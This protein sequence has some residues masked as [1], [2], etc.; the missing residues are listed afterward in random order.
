MNKIGILTFHYSIN[1]GAMMQVYSLSSKLKKEYPNLNV[2]VI[3]YRMPK[4]IDSYNYKLLDYLKDDNFIIT[5]KKSIKL[6]LDPLKLKRLNERTRI[7]SEAIKNLPLSDYMII[8]DKPDALFERINKEYDILIVGSDAVW[9]FV[10]RGFP[11][12]YFPGARVRCKKMS[13]AASCYGMDFSNIDSNIRE[14]ICDILKDFCFIGVRDKATEEF[15]NWSGCK[16]QPIH[17]CDPTAFLE[18][19][20]LPISED[21]VKEKMKKKGFDFSK[22]T[23]GIMGSEKMCRMVR[24]MFGNKYQI[25]AL[26]EYNKGA[27]VNLYDF[28]P[29]EWAYVF[30]YFKLTFTTYFHGTMLSLRNGIPLICVAL[31][32]EFAKKHTPKTL[33]LLQRLGYADWYFQTD[34]EGMNFDKISEK[35]NELLDNEMKK[36]I[37]VKMNKEAES[38]EEFKKNLDKICMMEKI[39]GVQSIVFTIDLF[40]ELI[41]YSRY[42]PILLRE[43]RYAA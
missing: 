41:K 6:L 19:D 31:D 15:V 25:V 13:Y 39:G 16:Q 23:I 17:T 1:N 27:D 36:E 20:N 35:A 43:M 10:M 37:L 33:D 5:L 42:V 12:A 9:N 21:I 8:D 14:Q 4:V 18:V 32:T 29:F 22:E 34:Y 2:E 30:R 28:N 3:D 24:Q 11:N 26:Y 38:F 7:F 40:N